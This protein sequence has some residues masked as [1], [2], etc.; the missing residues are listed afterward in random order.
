[1]T[2]TTYCTSVQPVVPHAPPP[3]LI[4]PPAQLGQVPPLNWSH[5]KPEFAGKP[6][7]DAEAHFLRTNDLMDIHVFQEGVKDQRFCLT[8]VGEARL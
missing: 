8:L 1:M 4:V 7:E 2:T 3:K 5:F 6:D